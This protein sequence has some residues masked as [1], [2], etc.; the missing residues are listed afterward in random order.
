MAAGPIYIQNDYLLNSKT[1]TNGD[2]TIS[3]KMLGL[4]SDA[5]CQI[6]GHCMTVLREADWNDTKPYGTYNHHGNTYCSKCRDRISEVPVCRYDV[7][8][9]QSDP[10]LIRVNNI[11]TDLAPA[12]KAGWLELRLNHFTLAGAHLHAGGRIARK[13][14]R[15]YDEKP[16]AWGSVVF[17]DR[18]SQSVAG[19]IKAGSYEVRDISDVFY[20]GSGAKMPQ[21]HFTPGADGTISLA[22]L[23]AKA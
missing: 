17:K 3:A 18:T 15:S 23:A 14:G 16:L 4:I 19:S 10:A 6:I 8:T 22:N 12:D 9:D 2:V 7:P 1:A 13:Q 20:D 11:N 21:Q 5:Y